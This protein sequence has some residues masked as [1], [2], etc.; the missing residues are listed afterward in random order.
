MSWFATYNLCVE[1]WCIQQG[2]QKNNRGGERGEEEGAKESPRHHT[3]ELVMVIL[4]RK[5]RYFVR[6]IQP[7]Y[8][9]VILRSSKTRV[10][11][12]I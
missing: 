11:K 10:D 1:L 12:T 8:H 3:G 6:L 9:T 5:T 4:K 2:R 7:H